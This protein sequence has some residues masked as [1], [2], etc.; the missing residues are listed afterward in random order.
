MVSDNKIWSR[1]FLFDRIEWD[2]GQFWD[3]IFQ[4]EHNALGLLI[5]WWDNP[6]DRH[7][8]GGTI[9]NFGF[10]VCLS[11]HYSTHAV[12]QSAKIR[13][14]W[15]GLGALAT[16][17]RCPKHSLHLLHH[18]AEIRTLSIYTTQK[19]AQIGHTTWTTHRLHHLLE[20]WWQSWHTSWQLGSLLS[21]D[22]LLDHV[23]YLARLSNYKKQVR[24]R[25][26]LGLL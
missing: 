8:L 2:A 5:L 19:L 14:L 26:E 6:G 24:F 3:W 9:G 23:K 15:S 22:L 11:I 7:L 1:I 13:H 17:R 25:W 21:C 12:H 18:G 20:S 4:S 10:L 16:G